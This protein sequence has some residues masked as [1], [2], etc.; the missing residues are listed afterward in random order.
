M[1]MQPHDIK[2]YIQRQLSIL[3]HMLYT[4]A[5][6]FLEVLGTK[7]KWKYSEQHWS[8]KAVSVMSYLQGETQESPPWG[9]CILFLGDADSL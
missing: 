9:L 4:G 5:K 2:G 6:Y 7:T 1:D 3:P 8:L